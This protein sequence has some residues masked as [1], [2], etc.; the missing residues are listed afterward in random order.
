MRVF[1]NKAF[2][3]YARKESITDDE[4]R[5]VIPLLEENNPDANLGGEVFKMRVA[6]PGDGKSGGYRVFVY[7]RSG[8]RT[9]FVHGLAKSNLANISDKDL[10]SLKM[11]AKDFFSYTEKQLEVLIK[12]GE[13]TEI[14]EKKHEEVSK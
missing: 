11:S 1:R 4:L 5:A 9:S 3:R 12:A 14:T 2:S 8:E 7:F 6:R 10:R 13:L